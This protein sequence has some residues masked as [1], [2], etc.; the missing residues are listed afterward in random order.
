M[1]AGWIINLLVAEWILM[2]RSIR[3]NPRAASARLAPF[4][5]FRY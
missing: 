4:T 3:Q 2:K 5:S 1:G